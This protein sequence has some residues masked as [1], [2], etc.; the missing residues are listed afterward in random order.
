MPVHRLLTH[1]SSFP[2]GDPAMAAAHTQDR[3][4]LSQGSFTAHT[5]GDGRPGILSLVGQNSLGLLPGSY[6][7]RIGVNVWPAIL[8]LCRQR[9]LRRFS[10]FLRQAHPKVASSDHHMAE[11]ATVQFVQK[12]RVIHVA[13]VCPHDTERNIPRPD[14]I[15]QIRGKL[16]LGLSQSH[17]AGIVST[18]CQS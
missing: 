7:K 12:V 10:H 11:L 2:P 1:Q 16:C 18:T 17:W 9:T 6:L 15:I 14:L 4:L 5:P 13:T 8:L 3:G